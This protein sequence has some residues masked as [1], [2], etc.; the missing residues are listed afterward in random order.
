M[1]KHNKFI[2]VLCFI[3]LNLTYAAWMASNIARNLCFCY[4]NLNR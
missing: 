3:R 4:E 1:N 2:N